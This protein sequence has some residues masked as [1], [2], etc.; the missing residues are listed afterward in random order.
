MNFSRRQTILGSTLGMVA[1]LLS[2]GLAALAQDT[3][4]DTFCAQYPENSRCENYES[5]SSAPGE[6]VAVPDQLIQ[7]QLNSNGP[8]DELI[9]IAIRRDEVGMVTDLTAYH[10]QR[11][12]SVLGG[13]LGAAMPMIPVELFEIY[14]FRDQQTEYLAFTPDT[15][16]GVPPIANGG[17]FQQAD[18]AIAGNGTIQLPE[19]VDI[20]AGFFTLGYTDN[21]LVKAIIFRLEDQEAA[22]VGDVH[23]DELCQNFPLNSR[24]QYWPLS[25]TEN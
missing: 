12:D 15:C 13:A 14:D 18:C 25:S 11:L 24:C 1:G 9:W 8:D 21:A 4:L 5:S 23:L 22:F 2:T 10:S 16:Q 7:V 19:D 6:T 3:D 20:R 17:G